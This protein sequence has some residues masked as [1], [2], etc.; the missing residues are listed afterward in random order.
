MGKRVDGSAMIE[1]RQVSG[2]HCM[3]SK[4]QSDIMGW[5]RR[6]AVL[7]CSIL[8][9][10][11]DTNSGHVELPRVFVVRQHAWQKRRRDSLIE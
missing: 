5:A 7:T 2:S 10:S 1:I 6:N 9:I 11:R 8:S 4:E 3:L